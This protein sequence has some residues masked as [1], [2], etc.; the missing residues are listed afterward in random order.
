VER[1][2]RW[3]R[4]G[5]RVPPVRGDASLAV[6]IQASSPHHHAIEI[7]GSSSTRERGGRE[8]PGPVRPTLHT[9]AG[10]AVTTTRR[11]RRGWLGGKKCCSVHCSAYELC[12]LSSTPTTMVIFPAAAED[13]DACSSMVATGEQ[14][15]VRQRVHSK[16]KKKNGTRHRSIGQ[17][18]LYPPLFDKWDPDLPHVRR[19]QAE[20][21]FGHPDHRRPRTISSLQWNARSSAV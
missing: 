19:S 21:N 5:V 10:L 20:G 4:R 18:L 2:E 15:A 12:S 6:Q 9:A 7:D 11:Y 13:P 8:V 3:R 17:L 14:L 16:T 1:R